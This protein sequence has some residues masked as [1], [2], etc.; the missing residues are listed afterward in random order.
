MN[1]LGHQLLSG[2]AFA[3]DQ[4]RSA[5]GSNLRDKVHHLLHALALADDIRQS[6]PLQ[7]APELHVLKLQPGL[8]QRIADFEQHPLVVPGLGDVAVRPFLGGLKGRLAGV[9][10]GNH[11]HAGVRIIAL[12]GLQDLEAAQ[13]R[14]ADIEQDHVKKVL[15]GFLQPFL[16]G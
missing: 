1:G 14:Q 4:Q 8:V 10:S 15:L 9:I 7:G 16:G 12:D 5:R 6:E 11:D 13:I 2:T 3:Q